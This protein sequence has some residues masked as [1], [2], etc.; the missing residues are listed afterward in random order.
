[1]YELYRI[2]RLRLDDYS[3]ITVGGTYTQFDIMMYN[4]K[5]LLKDYS[6]DVFRIVKV[7]I[8][9]TVYDTSQ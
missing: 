3:W 7:E 6:Y 1:M 2:Q 8:K 9:E 4:Y 5:N